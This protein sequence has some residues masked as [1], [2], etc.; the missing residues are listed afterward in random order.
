MASTMNSCA[1]PL[2]AP[3]AAASVSASL[4]MCSLPEMKTPGD[5][6][7]RTQFQS[8]RKHLSASL[9]MRNTVFRN[10]R[11]TI[12]EML[13]FALRLMRA[14][15]GEAGFCSHEIFAFG[16]EPRPLLGEFDD[17]RAHGFAA[18]VYG[19]P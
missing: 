7:S 19:Q 17:I 12:C 2:T 3:A 5:T 9:H 13:I 16:G 18:G 1:A 10:T 11:L 15:W 8:S 6:S 4:S 14:G